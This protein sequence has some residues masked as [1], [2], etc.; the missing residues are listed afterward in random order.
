[1]TKKKTF[2]GKAT[3]AQLKKMIA[4]DKLADL[5]KFKNKCD[6]EFA[7]LFPK[8]RLTRRRDGKVLVCKGGSR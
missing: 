3:K 6:R 5:I 1:M 7:R 8:A 2:K 4:M